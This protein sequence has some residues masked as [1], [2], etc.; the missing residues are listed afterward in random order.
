MEPVEEWSSET[1]LS[2]DDFE[3][4]TKYIHSNNAIDNKNR[5][6][7]LGFEDGVKVGVVCFFII[8]KG[9]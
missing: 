5:A 8:S 6:V 1:G 9:Y 2:R 4:F 7:I 3:K